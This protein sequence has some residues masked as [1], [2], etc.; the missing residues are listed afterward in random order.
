MYGGAIYDHCMYHSD[1]LTDFGD[2]ECFTD[3]ASYLR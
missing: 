2:R 1:S 3:I